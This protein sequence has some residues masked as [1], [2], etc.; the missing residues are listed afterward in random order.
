M[1]KIH[2]ENGIISSSYKNHVKRGV[3]D[4]IDMAKKQ[5]IDNL[6]SWAKKAKNVRAKKLTIKSDE[7]KEKI[8]KQDTDIDLNA[9]DDLDDLT[10]FRSERV[11]VG[12]D[13]EFVLRTNE[14]G[15]TVRD[16]YDIENPLLYS[17]LTSISPKQFYGTNAFVRFARF[18]KNL[19]TKAVTYDPGFFAG[20]NFIRDTISASI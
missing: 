4:I 13:Q 19:L 16:V 6:D 8:S 10:L 5:G 15:Q 9:I 12:K 2:I 17:T 1:G 14:K 18:W 11:S 7:I 3:F 20:A